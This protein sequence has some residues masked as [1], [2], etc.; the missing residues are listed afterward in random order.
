MP[1]VRTQIGK[2]LE[3]AALAIAPELIADPVT[4]FRNNRRPVNANGVRVSINILTDGLEAD[5]TVSSDATRVTEEF[6]ILGA[7]LSEDDEAAQDEIDDLYAA[8]VKAVMADTTLGG[9]VIDVRQAALQTDFADDEGSQPLGQF[10]L[11]L[12]I[13][14][15]T[16]QGDPYTSV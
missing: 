11:T 5:D 1:A 8:T 10:E 2:A 12:E 16:V 7:V 3:V 9:L 4:V 14:Y 13:Q 6:T 15:E